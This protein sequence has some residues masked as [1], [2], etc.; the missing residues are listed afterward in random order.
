MLFIRLTSNRYLLVNE[1]WILIPVMLA[2]DIIIIVKGKKNQ[3]KKKLQSEDQSE[4]WKKKCQ[5]WKI[6][7]LATG[8]LLAALETRGGE[9]IVVSLVETY[10]EVLHPQCIVGKGL[11]Y[12]NNER[13][14]K[15]VYSLFKSKAKNGVIYITNTALCHLVKIYGLDL[16]ALPFPIPDFLG[17]SSWYQLVRKIISVGFLGIPL[18]MLILAQG[19]KSIIISLAAGSLG[20]FGMAFIN[21]PGFLIIPTDLIS[22]PVDSIRRRI[23]DQPELVS[24]DLA[25]DAPSKVTMPA[26][27]SLPD[28][29]RF[30]P[31]C[32]LSSSEIVKVTANADLRYD[33]VVNMQDVTQLGKV[34]FSDQFEVSPNPKPVPNF[35]LRGTKRF[36]KQGKVTNFLEKYGDPESIPDADR[37]E[38]IIP[39]PQK[40]IRIPNREL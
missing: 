20:I 19:P 31:K 5:R 9:D 22:G 36:H 39:T 16:P 6:F 35:R 33:Q 2:I 23:P 26:Y 11:R 37:W 15:I 24:V 30:N 1:Y 17:V 4:R 12:V 29:S 8:N 7:H 13:L 32:R 27:C 38:S 10:V 40:S 28:Q 34:P 21:D 3:A 25:P 18:P 14:R